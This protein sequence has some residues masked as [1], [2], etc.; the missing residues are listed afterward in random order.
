V[1]TTPP[2]DPVLDAVLGVLADADPR[3]LPAAEL[4]NRLPE[5]ARSA[6]PTPRDLGVALTAH[7]EVVERAYIR[8]TRVWRATNSVSADSSVL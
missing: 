8:T 7:P 3:G 6:C 1:T 5:W 4:H 2:V